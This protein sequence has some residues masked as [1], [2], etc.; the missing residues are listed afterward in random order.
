MNY[1]PKGGQCVACTRRLDTNCK[2]LP[3][4]EMKVHRTDGSDA[5]VICS[6]FER[7]PQEERR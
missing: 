4:H 7:M 5:V 3:F 6:Y 2:N 1:F